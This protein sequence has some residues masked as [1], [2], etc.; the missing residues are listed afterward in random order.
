MW[1][2]TPFSSAGVARCRERAEPEPK[3][4]YKEN[5]YPPSG[6]EETLE[7]CSIVHLIVPPVDTST[8]RMVL[9]LRWISKISLPTVLVIA[10][11]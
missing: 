2:I 11:N 9:S 1:R 4:E 3:E 10:L 7:M 8:L 6:A 5:Y